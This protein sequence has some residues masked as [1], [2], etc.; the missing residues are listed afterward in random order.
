MERN[1]TSS[2]NV[3]S[4]KAISKPSKP[5]LQCR[6]QKEGTRQKVKDREEAAALE[7][8]GKWLTRPD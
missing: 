3:R 5:N 7:G 4:R 8:L 2:A 6:V 1:H